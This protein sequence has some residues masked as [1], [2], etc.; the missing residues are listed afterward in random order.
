M[1]ELIYLSRCLRINSG[2]LSEIGQAGALDC[3]QGAEMAQQR[4]FAGRPDARNL[5]QA[6]LADVLLAPRF[7]SSWPG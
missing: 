1:E 7:P 2:H 6:G 4:A 3:L 5:L